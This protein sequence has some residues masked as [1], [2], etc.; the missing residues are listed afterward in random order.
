MSGDEEAVGSV[1]ALR[2]RYG[3]PPPLIDRKVLPALDRH[4]RRFI[5]R[6]PL[7]M[8]ATADASGACDVS[9]RGD[10]PGFVQ[11]LS[12][13]RLAIPDRKGN[14]RL[15]A[16]RNVLENP[17]VGLCFVVPGVDDTLRVNGRAAIVAGD[18]ELLQ[19]MAVAGVVPTAALVVDVEEAFLH[20]GRAFKRGRVW[21]P[22][23]YAARGELPTLGEM[24]RDQT[25]PDADEQR[26]LDRSADEPLY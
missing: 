3:E 12:D 2:E 9:P 24:L 17:R 13:H 19:S 20:C 4:C 11:V 22:D 14:N 10:P 8:V 5:A 25:A 23:G 15:D 6:S 7:V 18:A 21:D 1:E 16:Y 26:L